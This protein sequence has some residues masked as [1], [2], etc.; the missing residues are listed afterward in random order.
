MIGRRRVEIRKTV[1]ELIWS[2]MA[3]HSDASIVSFI[4]D[5]LGL[6]SEFL[7]AE[8]HN[9]CT[10]GEQWLLRQLGPSAKTILDVGA[11]CGAWALGAH[12]I[13]PNAQIYCF[14]IASETRSQL[15]ANLSRL[16]NIHALDFGLGDLERPVRV[17]Y[18]PERDSL[19][20]MYDYP[21]PERC[22]WNTEMICRGDDFLQ[23]Q[24][25]DQID[26]LKVDTEGADLCVLKGFDAALSSHSISIVQFEYGY[27]CILSRSLLIDFYEYLESKEYVIGKLHA[28]HVDFR[29]YRL[30]DENFFGP[31][32]VAVSSRCSTIIDRLRL[33]KKT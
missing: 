23:S 27:A 11:N 16:P 33:I 25:L 24:G 18:Y 5:C 19:T 12:R 3:S 31:N 14:E 15:K 22:R 1:R 9:F 4:R 21:H 32:F 20:S 13:C 6:V 29:S 8:N 26:L 28:T 2:A 10:N 30:Q 17:K 7:H